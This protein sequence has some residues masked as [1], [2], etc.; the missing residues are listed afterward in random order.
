MED[1]LLAVKDRIAKFMMASAE[2]TEGS[3]A[4]ASPARV[5]VSTS[6]AIYFDPIY[7]MKKQEFQAILFD[8]NS[9]TSD[10][11]NIH[12]VTVIACNQSTGT[13]T[14]KETLD[15][16]VAEG[17]II[18][19]APN[20][21]EVQYVLIGEHTAI[22]DYPAICVTPASLDIDWMTLVGTTEK[23]VIR[24]ICHVKADNTENSVKTLSRLTMEVMDAMNADLH[25]VINRDVSS[26]YNKTYNSLAN[27]ATFGD[28]KKGNT[29][30][31]SSET[32]WFGDEF[33]SRFYLSQ[34]VLEPDAPTTG[35]TY[36]RVVGTSPNRIIQYYTLDADGV[37]TIVNSVFE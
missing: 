24:I 34:K 6:E 21:E 15:F 4:N 28:S 8:P 5:K 2:I 20:F 13:I 26:G 7:A 35:K 16:D 29:Y 3:A 14:L 25:L 17:W 23:S 19:R 30:L 32:N 11:S 27:K 31:L 18:K 22:P 37:E 12:P 9:D 36:V 10:F 1:V 33:W